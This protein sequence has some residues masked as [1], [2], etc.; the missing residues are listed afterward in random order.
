M[1]HLICIMLL[2]PALLE[3]Q[4]IS[5]PAV[6]DFDRITSAVTENFYDRTFKGLN[7]PER[8][9]VHR[10][11]VR[12][13]STDEEVAIG[14]NSLL[15][16]LLTS[17]THLYTQQDLEYWGLKSVFSGDLDAFKIP[18]SGI[19]PEKLNGRRYAKLV[20]NGSPAERAGVR[21]GDELRRLDG[22]EFAAIGF[23]PGKRSVIT[24]SHDGKKFR[25]V[26]ILP[27]V[28]SVQEAFL[29]ASKRSEKIYETA[30]KKIGYFHL[31][32]GTPMMNFC[33][34]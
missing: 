23:V 13:S 34:P 26:R 6:E 31:W 7:W 33:M 21:A 30:G 29:K 12:C 17:H 15:A 20:V 11:T 18:L 25:K 8:I 1:N 19:W 5:C 9:L 2:L 22:K 4:V 10:N 32:C 16:E 14:V 24:L 27:T 3:A 28:E